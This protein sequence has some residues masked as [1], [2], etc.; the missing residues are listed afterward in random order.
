MSIRHT[1]RPTHN[2]T[3]TDGTDTLGLTLCDPRGKPDPRAIRE[4]PMP[5]TSLQI[6]QGDPTYG[7]YQLPYTPLVQK[8]WSGGRALFEFNKDST[9]YYDSQGIDAR[10]GDV[11]LGPKV[12]NTSGTY[13]TDIIRTG[14]TELAD[15]GTYYASSF[16]PA[17]N[18]EVHGVTAT[19]VTIYPGLIQ[20][21]IYDDVAGHPGAIIASGSQFVSETGVDVEVFCNIYANLTGGTKYW[22]RITTV[23][24]GSIYYGAKA[25]DKIMYY[26]GGTWWD[27]VT[28]ASL[29]FTLSTHSMGLSKFFEYKGAIFFILQPDDDSTPRLYYN[30]YRG[31]I[32]AATVDKSEMLTSLDLSGVDLAGKVVRIT[33][34]PGFGERVAWRKIVYNTQTGTNDTITVWPAWNLAHTTSTEFAILGTD[35]WTTIGGTGLTKPV[36]DVLVVDDIIYFAQGDVTPIRRAQISAGGTFSGANE[37]DINATYKG[38]TFL[39][40]VPETT[41]K[42][43][44]WYAQATTSKVGKSDVKTWGNN[45]A[46]GT[47]IVCGNPKHK[48]TSLVPYGTPQVPWV[49]KEDSF[50]SISNGVYAPVPLQEMASVRSEENGVAAT[51]FGLY[52]FFSLLDGLE[53]F[54]DNR[55]DDL[56]PNKDEGFP[57][58]RKGPIVDLIPYPGGIFAALNGGPGGYSSILYWN[59][60]GWHELYRGAFGRRIQ[61]IYIQII[62]GNTADRLWFS[63]EEQV[64]WLPISI[65]P[66]KQADYTFAAS[67]DLITSWH[68]AGFGEITKYWSSLTLHTDGLVE[69]EQTITA[70]YQTDDEDDNDAWHLIG[71]FITSPSQKLPISATHDVSGKRIRFKLTFATTDSAK[72]PRLRAMTIQAVTRVP[73]AKSWSVTFLAA[74]YMQDQQGRWQALDEA[75]LRAQLATW[76]DSDQHAIPLLMRASDPAYDSR[77]VFIDPAS[78]N[79]VEFTVEAN[80]QARTVKAMTMAIFEADD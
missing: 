9:R 59:Q 48:I 30:G 36:T 61:S 70:Y 29:A 65:N 27:Q 53:R 79:P 51:Q 19:I 76:A 39:A 73:P 4:T 42:R 50:G 74:S 17:A 2:L 10:M 26:G 1:P 37:A 5:K 25:G 68:Q 63:E 35:K 40:M 52:L 16:T 77:Y 64:A 11:L 46:F 33:G 58:T 60:V 31:T 66:R 14:T 7:S 62:P 15:P 47:A 43:K 80:G 34:G 49:I 24:T 55:L 3:F 45:L 6:S 23:N 21:A 18:T 72:S 78:V 54:Y 71:T 8:D 20:F 22:M 12:T 28:N 67:G 38:A 56:G 41:G 69:D 44:V 13:K 32:R 57:E 75:G